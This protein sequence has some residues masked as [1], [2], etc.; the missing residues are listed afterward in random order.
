MN[1]SYLETCTKVDF[2]DFRTLSKSAHDDDGRGE[3]SNEE[4]LWLRQE[5]LI[6]EMDMLTIAFYFSPLCQFRPFRKLDIYRSFRKL[7]IF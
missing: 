2:T 5:R 6:Y 7:D 3:K 4:A 1:T